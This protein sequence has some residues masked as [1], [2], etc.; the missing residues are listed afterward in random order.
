M[1]SPLDVGT[2][3]PL[4]FLV[5]LGIGTGI[6]VIERDPRREGRVEAVGVM[7][8]DGSTLTGDGKK[9]GSASSKSSLDMSSEEGVYESVGE[10]VRGGAE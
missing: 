3:R 6:L 5:R 4:D 7:R 1:G 2:L 8:E 9:S 10:S